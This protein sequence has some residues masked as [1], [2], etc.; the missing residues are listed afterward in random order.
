MDF[1]SSLSQASTKRQ[2]AAW[3]DEAQ[4]IICK[5]VEELLVELVSSHPATRSLFLMLRNQ[6]L[7]LKEVFYIEESSFFLVFS[8][9]GEFSKLM[10]S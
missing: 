7:P 9:V 2:R 1:A 6:K 3:R 5:K 4:T 8:E 10:I